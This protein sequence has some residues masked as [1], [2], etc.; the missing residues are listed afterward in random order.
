MAANS[1]TSGAKP[2]THTTGDASDGAVTWRHMNSFITEAASTF[3]RVG[4]NVYGRSASNSVVD[5][6]NWR[7]N[8]LIKFDDTHMG[9]TGNATHTIHSGATGTGELAFSDGAVKGRIIY[10]H[11]ND[12][13]ELYGNANKGFQ[14]TSGYSEF[15]RGLVL[16]RTAQASSANA[17]ITDIYIG[18]TNTSAPRTITMFNSGRMTGMTF[19]IKDESGG[20]GNNHITIDGNGA[21][22]NGSSTLI[23]RKNYGSAAI[24]WDSAKWVVQWNDSDTV[25]AVTG[26]SA[27]TLD[28]SYHSL[29]NFS[30][31][32]YAVTSSPGVKVS[33]WGSAATGHAHGAKPFEHPA[34]TE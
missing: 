30:G 23:I 9:D 27:L 1:A 2:P 6:D 24:M 34:N 12:R 11:T 26:A 10:D 7:N 13:L 3:N 25:Q 8:T 32:T 15:L 22:V 4:P 16:K 17:A 14:V 21:N 19:I 28:A 20:A 29:S 31:S 18:V 33:L 5:T